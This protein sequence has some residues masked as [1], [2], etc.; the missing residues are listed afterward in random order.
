[1]RS[2]ELNGMLEKRLDIEDPT[3]EDALIGWIGFMGSY[4]GR[5]FDGGYSG[6]CVDTASGKY[7]YIARN[8]RSVMGQ[9]PDLNG[10]E[11]TCSTYERINLPSEPSIIYCD[12]PYKSTKKYCYGIDH[13]L[14][15]EWCRQLS[16]KGHK[17]YISEYDAPADFSCVWEKSI[18]N[19]MYVEGKSKYN[20]EKLF[21]YYG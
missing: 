3:S 20:T 13:E 16:S 11:F 15:W 17:V 19:N 8:I 18:R 6:H 9:I 14:F 10:V 21:T 1:M 4:N 12:P 2:I 7:D 5:F